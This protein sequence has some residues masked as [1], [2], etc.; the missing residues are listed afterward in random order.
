MYIRTNSSI[1]Y[2]E[3]VNIEKLRHI[4]TRIIKFQAFIKDK[5]NSNLPNKNYKTFI[6]A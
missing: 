5:K 6:T 2:F 3:Y 4:V 1:I